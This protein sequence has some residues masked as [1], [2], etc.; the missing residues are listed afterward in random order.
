MG[1]ASY[2]S[3]PRKTERIGK[4]K[5][6]EQAHDTWQIDGKELVCLESGEKFSW[7]NIG[8]EATAAHLKATVHPT[9]RVS[10]IKLQA[11]IWA[12][13]L[14]FKRWGLPKRIKIDNGQPFVNPNYRD[15]P[16]K[17]KLWWIGLGIEVIQN[18][19]RVPQENGIEECLQGVCHRW[20]NPSQI[21]KPE[22][23]QVE[24]DQISNFQRNHYELPNRNYK[25]RIE[26]YPEL[27]TNSRKY[28]PKQF[29]MRLVDQYL[30]TQVWQRKTNQN[31][32]L[33]FLDQKISIG[34]AFK[35]QKVYITFD[36]IERQWVIRN[37]KGHLLKTS[38]K[39]VPSKEELKNFAVM[40][41]N[42]KGFL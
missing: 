7:M 14:S 31:G 23:L 9:P 18:T 24:L 39:A 27:E 37:D 19:P 33:S 34:R 1:A 28:K 29:N 35:N 26:L 4:K 11:A 12:I 38:F 3:P 25:T 15:V 13:N 8:D 21:Q 41:K 40:S 2:Q 32:Q 20:V 42:F 22:Q 36:E 30:A 16:T 5:W 6:T 17:A 10:K